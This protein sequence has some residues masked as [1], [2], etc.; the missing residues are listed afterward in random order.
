MKVLGA[1]PN[2]SIA[3]APS[4]QPHNRQCQPRAFFGVPIGLPVRRKRS[5][6]NG[7]AL[8]A[9]RRA[10]LHDLPRGRHSGRQLRS[11]PIGH[12]W[13]RPRSD[14]WRRCLYLS[15][16]KDRHGGLRDPRLYGEFREP[17]HR[18][19]EWDRCSSGPR[20][21]TI[22]QQAVLRG[23]CG[24]LLS[25]VDRRQGQLAILGPNKSRTRGVGP[26][27][28]YNFKIGGVSIYTNVR[29]YTEFDS[30]RR[31][32]GHAIYSTVNIPV[33][34]LFRGHSQ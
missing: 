20:C 24:I 26:Q 28:G 27:I 18:L 6:P 13:D 11:Q 22:S 19:Q 8:L 1:R 12:Y 25:T 10:Q 5:L 34:A 30:F 23:C 3:F 16:R 21:G 32:Q 7:A 2:F 31:L 15:Q 4:L 9:R 17:F 14:R 29:G 33:S